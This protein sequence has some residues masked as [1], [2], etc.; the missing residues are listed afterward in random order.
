LAQCGTGTRNTKQRI[1][2]LGGKPGAAHAYKKINQTKQ[3]SALRLTHN[4]TSGTSSPN[5]GKSQKQTKPHV[6]LV[7]AQ[8]IF[9]RSKTSRKAAPT[10]RS[11][12]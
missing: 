5:H 4:V 6:S 3:P 12:I 1:A 2:P 11:A 10:K 9:P 7:Q 8:A